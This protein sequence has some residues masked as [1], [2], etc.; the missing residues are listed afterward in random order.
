VFRCPV[1][2]E[3]YYIGYDPKPTAFTVL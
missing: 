3:I 1:T 2:N